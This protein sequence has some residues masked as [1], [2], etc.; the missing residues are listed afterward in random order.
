MRKLARESTQHWG[1]GLSALRVPSNCPHI[2]RHEATCRVGHLCPLA[3]C[4][5]DRCPC[6]V[7][8]APGTSPSPGWGD[9]G[10]VGAVWPGAPIL[11]TSAASEKMPSGLTRRHSQRQRA[12]ARLDPSCPPGQ[13]LTCGVLWWHCHGKHVVGIAAKL[14]SFLP[15]SKCKRWQRGGSELPFASVRQPTWGSSCQGNEIKFKKNKK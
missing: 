14:I 9:S 2:P 6:A 11:H 8:A 5:G 7:T 3:L 1:G 12:Q 10:A 15:L 4:P 13:P